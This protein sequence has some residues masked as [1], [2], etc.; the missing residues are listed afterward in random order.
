HHHQRQRHQQHRR[1]QPVA[2]PHTSTRPGA[3]DATT[4]VAEIA[5]AFGDFAPIR[6]TVSETVAR[7][8]WKI[9][10]AA[11]INSARTFALSRSTQAQVTGC[12]IAPIAAA[13]RT[14]ATWLAL[15][16]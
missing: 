6:E 3:H 13:T 14:W 12:I 8:P 5:A 11:S 15:L 16:P 2:I 4:R 10:T 7:G 1:H 9:A